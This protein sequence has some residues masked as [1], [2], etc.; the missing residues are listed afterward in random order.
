MLLNAQTCNIKVNK[1][2]TNI[3]LVTVGYGWNKNG[4]IHTQ[5]LGINIDRKD[6]PDDLMP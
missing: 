2:L 5:K 1:S 3:I 6:S 4:A